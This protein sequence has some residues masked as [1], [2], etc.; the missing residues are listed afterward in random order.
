MSTPI[1]TLILAVLLAA[2]P[3]P[4]ADDGAA[5][6]TLGHPG[7]LV[8]A[9][10]ADT[11]GV[12]RWQR[13]PGPG[14]RSLVWA[15][16]LLT[17]PAG[18]A[19]E[20]FGPRDLAVAAGAGLTGTSDG[21]DLIFADGSYD[22]SAPVLLSDGQVSLYAAAGR[23]EILGERIRYV[24]PRQSDRADPRAGF[25][26]LAGMVLLVVVLLRLTRRRRRSVGP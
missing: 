2:V 4:A 19:L 23:L 22:V 25:A 7:Y 8:L 14:Q 9:G 16:G 18:L 5:G 12:Y 20:A 24:P 6:T 15:D 26:F 21:G 1:G 3:A 10:A 11:T 13:G 17:L